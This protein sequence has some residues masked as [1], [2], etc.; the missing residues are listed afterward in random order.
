MTMR[1]IPVLIT[2]INTPVELVPNVTASSATIIVTN[3][4][5]NNPI[6]IGNGN[7]VTTTNGAVIPPYGI[8]TME[9]VVSPGSVWAVAGAIDAGGTSVGV[10]YGD[11]LTTP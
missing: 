10:V 5:A 7:T 4:S 6:F 2:A 1:L 8:I 3:G 11:T 9:G